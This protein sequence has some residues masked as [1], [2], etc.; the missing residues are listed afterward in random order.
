MPA[1]MIKNII[2]NITYPLRMKLALSRPIKKITNEDKTNIFISKEALLEEKR[3]LLEYDFKYLQNDSSIVHYKENLYTLKLLED[4]LNKTPFNTKNDTLKILDIGSKNFSYAPAIYNFFKHFKCSN[5]TKTQ[6]ILNGIE[7]DP[8]R[9][10]SDLHSRYDY[11]QYYIKNLDNT[12]YI[13]GNLLDHDE[14][15]YDIITWFLPFIIKDPLISWG[16][17]ARYFKPEKMLKH[18]YKLLSPRGII[19]LVNQGKT[20]KQAQVDLIKELNLNYTEPD[21]SYTNCFSPYK[22]ERYITIITK[23]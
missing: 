13:T 12:K 7:I 6:V 20:E 1:D 18:A 4:S 2:N 5:N 9:M 19:L 14:N 8:Y 15:N 16:L 3:I 22:L 21:E 23:G 17:P 11:A 10:L